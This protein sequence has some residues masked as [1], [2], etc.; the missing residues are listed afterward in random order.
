[1]FFI[2]RHGCL[3]QR[4]VC[5]FQFAWCV[6]GHVGIGS[7]LVDRLP[8]I[9]DGCLRGRDFGCRRG[10]RASRCDHAGNNRAGSRSDDVVHHP[11]TGTGGAVECLAQ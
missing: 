10:G 3:L 6:F 7:R 11:P 5:A 9:A 2:P 4:I 8:G 1:M